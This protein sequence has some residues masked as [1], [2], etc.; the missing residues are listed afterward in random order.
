[1]LRSLLVLAT[2]TTLTVTA[3]A[4]SAETPAAIDDVLAS[5]GYVLGAGSL[6]IQRAIQTGVSLE[7]GKH[8]PGTHRFIRGQLAF[9]TSGDEGDYQQV[10]IGYEHRGC[11]ANGS[12]CA[13]GGI[14][15]G[16]QH[17]HV[18][19]R[20]FDWGFG[21]G[22]TAAYMVDAHD[23]L[24]VPRAGVELGRSIKARVSLEL[25]FY[26]RLDTHM[27]A[28]R[29]DGGVGLSVSAGLGYAF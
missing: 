23:V 9:G 27:D 1:M 29:S 5:N 3:S 15:A 24:L 12:L 7:G 20:T 17:D 16:Y 6:G 4:Q 19:R 22:P 11:V 28:D 26:R 13:F 10:R 25:P 8:I 21:D 18:E 2:L 14:D